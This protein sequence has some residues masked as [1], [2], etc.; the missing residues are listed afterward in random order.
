[1]KCP[2]EALLGIDAETAPTTPDATLDTP[3]T[4]IET[5]SACRA[6]QVDR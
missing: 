6:S 3:D 4:A 2:R 1:M 5:L